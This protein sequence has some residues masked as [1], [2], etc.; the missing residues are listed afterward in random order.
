FDYQPGKTSGLL[1][2]TLYVADFDVKSRTISNA[3]PFANADAK[4]V[5][6][7]YPRWTKDGAAIV[8]HANRKLFLYTLADGSTKKVSTDEKADY[9]YP[10][11]EATPN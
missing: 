3:K 10:H 11:G 5:W 1:G 8:Y 9:R 2:R 7:D 6:F 4:K